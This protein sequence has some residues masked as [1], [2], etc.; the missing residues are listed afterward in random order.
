MPLGLWQLNYEAP[1]ASSIIPH[2]ESGSKATIYRPQRVVLSRVRG[3]WSV[4]CYPVFRLVAIVIV[5]VPLV[6]AQTSNRESR[7]LPSAKPF[8]AASRSGRIYSWT[9]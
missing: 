2:I 5:I 8:T 7:I 3:L 6:S 1:N 9:R 4:V